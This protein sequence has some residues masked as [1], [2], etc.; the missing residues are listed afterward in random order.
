MN[1]RAAPQR[2][3]AP[4]IRHGNGIVRWTV[5]VDAEGKIA[6]A[7]RRQQRTLASFRVPDVRTGGSTGLNDPGRKPLASLSELLSGL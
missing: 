3:D 7:L 1:A 2:A 4:N 6:G 5:V